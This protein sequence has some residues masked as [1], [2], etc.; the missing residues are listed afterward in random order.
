VRSRVGKRLAVTVHGVEGPV[1]LVLAV[2]VDEGADAV[3]GL[4]EIGAIKAMTSSTRSPS[5]VSLRAHRAWP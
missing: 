5:R 3:N 4:M 1:D 2:V